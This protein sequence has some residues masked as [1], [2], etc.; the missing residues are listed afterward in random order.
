MQCIHI[1]PA[2][3]LQR[4]RDDINIFP[5][6]RLRIS[7]ECNMRFF[8]CSNAKRKRWRNATHPHEKCTHLFKRQHHLQN[9]IRIFSAFVLGDMCIILRIIHLIRQHAKNTF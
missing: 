7:E 2:D 1:H 4:E 8:M 5:S 3:S 9:N 6:S